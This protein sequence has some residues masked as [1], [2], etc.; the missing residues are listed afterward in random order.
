VQY[1]KILDGEVV[2][3]PYSIQEVKEDNPHVSFPV[4]IPEDMLESYGCFKVY[5]GTPPTD[6][7]LAYTILR[8][9]MPVFN[10]TRWEIN[11]YSERLPIEHASR[12]VRAE[13]DMRLSTTDWVV[14]KSIEAGLPIPTQ[15]LEYRQLLRDIS[16]QKEFPWKVEWPTI[17]E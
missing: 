5:I 4:D 10:G 9:D 14:T 6:N 17:P 15:Y 7:I 16:S 1:A 11:Y 12:N 2:K 13:R 3:F 8:A